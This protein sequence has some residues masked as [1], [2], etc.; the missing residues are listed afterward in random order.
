MTVPASSHY[1]TFDS[2]LKTLWVFDLEMGRKVKVEQV[3]WL[4]ERNEHNEDQVAFREDEKGS[5]AKKRAWEISSVRRVA[6]FCSVLFCGIR[7]PKG[8]ACINTPD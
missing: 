4:K 6:I 8:R 2:A 1:S 7:G 5:R 3:A